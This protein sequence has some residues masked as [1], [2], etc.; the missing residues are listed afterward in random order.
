MAIP[1]AASAIYDAETTFALKGRGG[2]EGNPI[3]RPIVNAGRGP[4][5]AALGVEAA[6]Q[7]YLGSKLRDAGKGYWWVPQ[8]LSTVGHIAMG[9]M[10][11]GKR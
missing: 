3:M 4:T 7:A 5:Y 1:Q 8:A 9:T 10:N 2:F 6:G 11:R